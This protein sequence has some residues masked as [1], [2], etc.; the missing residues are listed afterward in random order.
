[1]NPQQQKQPFPSKLEIELN[2]IDLCWHQGQTAFKEGQKS[3]RNVAEILKLS[4][5]S[6]FSTKYIIKKMM[7]HLGHLN[8]MS[9]GKLELYLD[10]LK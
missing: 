10:D 6:S 2:K 8:G 7:S 3:I 4:Y 9:Y 5:G 1:M